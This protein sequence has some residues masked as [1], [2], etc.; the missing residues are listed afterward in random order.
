LCNFGDIDNYLRL[1]P[2]ADRLKILVGV[3]S[4][5]EYLHGERV[6]HGDIKPQNILVNDRH[7]PVLCDFGRSRIIGQRGFTTKFAGGARYMAPEL[8]IDDS[9]HPPVTLATDI[10]TFAIVGAE[11]LTGRPAFTGSDFNIGNR[12]MR[13]DRPQLQNLRG[14]AANARPILDACWVSEPHMRMPMNVAAPHLGQL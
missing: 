12:V 7:T 5:L 4:G 2:G 10:Y 13:G 11:I 6:V 14:R 3:A 1:Y 8:I 9:D